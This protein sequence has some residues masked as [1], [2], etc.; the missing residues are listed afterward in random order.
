[1]KL[2]YEVHSVVTDTLSI[3]A[4]V[5]GKDREVL[6]EVLTVELTAPGSAL[7]FRFDDIPVAEKLFAKGKK[8]TLTFAGAK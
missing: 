8:V 1:M 6:S 3:I 4:Q 2:V 5:N 7:T